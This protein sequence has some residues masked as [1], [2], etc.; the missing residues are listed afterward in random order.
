M[1]KKYIYYFSSFT[2]NLEKK[3]N[4][5]VHISGCNLNLKLS[6]LNQ[7]V[8]FN[9]YAHNS[10]NY[11]NLHLFRMCIA[12]QD[13]T[14]QQLDRFGKI[15]TTRLFKKRPKIFFKNTETILSIKILL[16]CDNLAG[17][18]RCSMSVTERGFFQ[19]KYGRLPTCPMNR[20]IQFHDSF[21]HVNFGLATMIDDLYKVSQTDGIALEKSFST[22]YRYLIEQAGYEY[23]QFLEVIKSKLCM[24][25]ESKCSLFSSFRMKKLYQKGKTC[26]IKLLSFFF[27]FFQ[28]FMV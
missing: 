13:H 3:L 5:C 4:L 9:V 24:P 10:Q 16:S 6:L 7:R 19:E 14:F 27:F 18:D 11:D 28:K 26:Q 1:G 12:L 25:F 22:S 23:P 15:R 2:F 20:Y 17:C 8:P 21:R